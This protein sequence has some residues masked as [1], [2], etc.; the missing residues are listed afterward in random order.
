MDFVL[1]YKLTILM[2]GLTGFLML[3]QLA[4]SDVISIK[5]KHTPGYA[6]QEDH[7][8]L[9]FR[10]HRAFANSNESVGLFVLF[11]LFGILSGANP[12]W[13]NAMAVCFWVGR[14]GHM[15]CYYTGL[16]TLRSIAFGI[17]FIGLIGMFITGIG[18]WL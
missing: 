18:S 9:L 17:S 10:A 1:P 5:S 7:K 6:V 15:L 12:S 16:S 11:V 13:L 2:V 3:L 4:I 8:D 14:V